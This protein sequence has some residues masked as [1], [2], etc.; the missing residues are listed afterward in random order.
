MVLHSHHPLHYQCTALALIHDQNRYWWRGSCARQRFC[1]CDVD[2]S[3]HFY[4]SC[5]TPSTKVFWE[6][7]TALR[8][9]CRIW[10][11]TIESFLKRIEQI[12]CD[13]FIWLRSKREMLFDFCLESYAFFHNAATVSCKRAKAALAA[14]K[15]GWLMFACFKTFCLTPT[16]WKC[17]AVVA[18]FLH[19]NLEKNIRYQSRTWQPLKKWMQY[20]P[21]SDCNN[22]LGFPTSL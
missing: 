10:K 21:R 7:I 22:M 12:L 3:E 17:L 1:V 18:I 19:L 9:S 6:L 13:S 15:C 5:K 14:L 16:W 2:L 8:T 20:K 11:G 4:F